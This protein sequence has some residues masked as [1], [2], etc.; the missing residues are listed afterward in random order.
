[1][2]LLI[3]ER[4]VLEAHSCAHRNIK[5]QFLRFGIVLVVFRLAELDFQKLEV[6]LFAAVVFNRSELL[7][8]LFKV[9]FEELL[10]GVCLCSNK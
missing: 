2:L 10:I 4:L 1:M 7:K 6:K 9:T 8:G 3:I 5:R